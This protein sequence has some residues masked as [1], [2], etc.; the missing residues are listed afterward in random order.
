MADNVISLEVKNRVISLK[1]EA[2]MPPTQSDAGIDFVKISLDDEW[3]GMTYVV[4]FDNHE[5]VPVEWD[6][7]SNIAVPDECT[8]CAGTLRIGVEG[9]KDEGHVELHTKMMRYGIPV[10]QKSKDGGSGPNAPT[11]SIVMQAISATNAAN[12]AAESAT[13]ATNAANEAAQGARNAA[14]VSNEAAD[15]ADH[16]ATNA[17]NVVADLRAAVQRG[18]FNGKDG[19][20]PS[21]SV[22]RVDGGAVITITDKDGTTSAE[23]YDGQGGGGSTAWDD[24]TGKP[25]FAT[26]ATS[27]SYNDLS[28]KPTIPTVPNNVSAFNNDAGYLTDAPVD[29]VQI[30]GASIVADGVAE[31]P[32]ASGSSVGVA[33]FSSAN[34]IGISATGSAYVADAAPAKIDARTDAYAPITPRRLDYAVRASLTDGK[35]VTAGLWDEESQRKARETIGLGGDFDLIEEITLTES[36]TLSRSQSPSGKSYNFK[37]ALVR[38]ITPENTSFPVSYVAFRNSDVTSDTAT[39]ARCYLSSAGATTYKKI[40]LATCL[41]FNGMKLALGFAP[42]NPYSVSSTIN[43]WHGYNLERI[44]N[45]RRIDIQTAYPAG[46]VIQIYGAWA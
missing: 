22:E 1:D 42:N 43:H 27:G 29:D 28:S 4:T 36:A 45:V 6:G 5:T 46:T 14:A 26:V 39:V 40:A 25:S 9:F 19:T 21:A 11:P 44:G 20:S 3:E 18:D 41:D 37:S 34:G 24:I 31:I 2:F 38:V 8:R 32:L 17:I 23:V 33:K 30:N 7:T 16:A 15:L 10:P 12:E 35:A 13:A